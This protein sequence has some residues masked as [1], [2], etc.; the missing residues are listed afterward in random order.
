MAVAVWFSSV[1]VAFVVENCPTC[2][3]GTDIYEARFFSI[4][5]RRMTR[6]FPTVTELIAKDRGIPCQ[7][8]L[9]MRWM[10]NHQ[11]G[12]CLWGE[13][14]IGI[15]RLSGPPW[16]PL[17][18]RNAVRS[19]AAQ[20]PGFIRNFHERA[21]EGQDREYVKTLIFQMYDACSVEQLPA[22]LDTEYQ[23]A[24]SPLSSD[25]NR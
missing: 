2:G 14:F 20:D 5:R 19:W 11:F 12:G 21:L 24:T 23:R 18:A 17:C 10:R 1:E 25:R 7:H 3:H 16:Y 13:N 9:A 15:H 22:N 6:D 8:Q 4:I